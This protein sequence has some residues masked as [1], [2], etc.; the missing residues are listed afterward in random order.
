MSKYE[1]QIG[2]EFT[3]EDGQAPEEGETRHRGHH[4]HH[5]HGYRGWRHRFQEKMHARM[6]AHMHADH[7]CRH[8]EHAQP[9][10]K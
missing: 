4:H 7:G 8:G 2:S 3:L 1:P 10:G 6:A 9:E 5:G